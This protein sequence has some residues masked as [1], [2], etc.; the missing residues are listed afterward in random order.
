[1]QHRPAHSLSTSQWRPSHDDALRQARL[2]FA[3]KARQHLLIR[4]CQALK[5]RAFDV[6]ETARDTLSKITNSLGI[7]YFPFI[8]T[9]LRSSLIKGYQLHVLGATLYYILNKFEENIPDGGLD[10]SV[11]SIIEVLTQD[12][13]GEPAREREVDKISTKLPEARSTKSF[14]CFELVAKKM[15]AAQLMVLITPLKE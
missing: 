11:Q 1:M 12:I 6:R 3:S 4:V 9:E 15:S 2:L 14:E 10:V 5:S 8:L 13:F 7:C